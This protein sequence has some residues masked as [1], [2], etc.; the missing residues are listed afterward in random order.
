MVIIRPWRRSI[1]I[2]LRL[3]WCCVRVLITSALLINRH[4]LVFFTF[5]A[6][7]F[8][9]ILKWFSGIS[10][11]VC[12]CF[13]VDFAIFGNR[14]RYVS[15]QTV[16]YVRLLTFVHVS[17]KIATIQNA[18]VHHVR[19]LQWLSFAHVLILFRFLSERARAGHAERQRK[20]ESERESVNALCCFRRHNSRKFSR[21]S[22]R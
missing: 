9:L 13:S 7:I 1:A 18:S 14:Y 19:A 3:F 6:K 15:M 11:C 22:V 4:I 12:V 21:H 10:V 20:R 8:P 17:A 5:M 16:M 2:F